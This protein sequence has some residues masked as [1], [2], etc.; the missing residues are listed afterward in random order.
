MKHRFELES[1]D[2][3]VRVFMEIIETDE[4]RSKI[5]MMHGITGTDTI[6]MSINSTR[7]VQSEKI[8]DDGT[9][10]ETHKRVERSVNDG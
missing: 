4:N 9:V 8:D 10:I 5:E 7:I 3:N 6:E 1:K 2:P